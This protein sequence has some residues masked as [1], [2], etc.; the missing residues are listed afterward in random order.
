MDPISAE[1]LAALAGGA[2]G[3]MGKQAWTSLSALVRKPFAHVDHDGA[4]QPAISSG[5][6]EYA[7]LQ[8]QPDDAARALALSTA[9]ALRASVDDEFRSALHSWQ[10]HSRR[11]EIGGTSISPVTN[12]IS[13]GTFNAPVVMGNDFSR[14]SFGTP[15]RT[16]RSRPPGGNPPE[17]RPDES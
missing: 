1:V 7:G 14:L 8:T 2:G 5:E 15:P 16:E 3:E 17:D 6:P 10:D 13:G 9:L 4:A 11:V 12:T